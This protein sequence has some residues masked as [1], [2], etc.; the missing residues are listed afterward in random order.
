MRQ[1]TPLMSQSET[2][3][4]PTQQQ[5]W[6]G[7]GQAA[8]WG[9]IGGAI[10]G[11]IGAVAGKA[12]PYVG[13]WIGKAASSAK[14]ATSAA[15][16][17]APRLIAASRQAA[18]QSAQITQSLGNRAASANA[19]AG[20]SGSR[21]SA[22][23][24]A[25][26]AARDVIAAAHPGSKIEQSLSTTAGLRR[27]DVL[28]QGRVG[29]EVKVGRTSLTAAARSQIAKDVLLLRSGDVTGIEWVFSRSAVTGLRGPT[30]PLAKALSKENIPW[31]LVP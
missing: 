21:I 3:P 20:P 13:N 16:N 2:K 30:G 10:G 7:M 18:A 15:A 17:T 5:Y 26:N 31:S 6:A 19:S 22:N 8:V 25:G 28:T 29:I 24:A 23:Q 12:A 4:A 11:G 27:L 14:N 9:G 1:E